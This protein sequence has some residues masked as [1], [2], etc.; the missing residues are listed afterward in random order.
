MHLGTGAAPGKRAAD[1][2]HRG[3]G[4]R[5]KIGGREERPRSFFHGGSEKCTAQPDLPG[6]GARWV[7]ARLPL[8]QI[9]C[10]RPPQPNLLLA[11]W[12]QDYP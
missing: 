8:R 9:S 1:R 7:A 12:Q 3:A 6:D 10:I 4:G 11:G 2:A 5:G